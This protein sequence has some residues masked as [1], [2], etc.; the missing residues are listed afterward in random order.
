MARFNMVL[1]IAD[2][3]LLRKA[4][5]QGRCSVSAL[6]RSASVDRAEAMLQ[7]PSPSKQDEQ[8]QVDTTRAALG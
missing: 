7:T 5:N 1:D 8:E 3:R 2:L 6:V 4:A